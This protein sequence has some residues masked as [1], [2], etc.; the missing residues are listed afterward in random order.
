[1][2]KV[3]AVTGLNAGENPQPGAGVIRSLRRAF[4]EL[5]IV[6]LVYGALESAIYAED[7]PDAVYQIPYPSAGIDPLLERLD[8]LMAHEPIDLFIPTLDAEILPLI[9][10]QQA[11]ADR[12]IVTS[13]PSP[14]SFEARNKS[15][16]DSLVKKCGAQVPPGKAIHSLAELDKV[17][18]VL[19]F[20]L[21][22]K[23]PYYDAH[24]AHTHAELVGHFH[25]IMLEW[26]GPV[27][28]QS[29]I[30]GEE[31]NIT[32]LG[33][34]LGGLSAC[35]MIRKSIRSA[36]GKGFGGVVVDDPQL[37][38]TCKRIIAELKWNGPMELEFIQ[39]ETSGEFYLLEMNP[40]FPAWIDFPARI[41]CNMPVMLLEQM[42]GKP[43][44][45]VPVQCPVGHFFLRHSVDLSGRIE[46]LGRL[47]TQGELIW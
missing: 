4:N 25:S 30:R 18:E 24:L 10:A 42:T 36:K 44:P 33:D 29:F 2:K 34:G 15:R 28:V 19:A 23:G 14:E 11:L 32:G 17:L 21:M 6:G 26:G 22:V 37:L 20:P 35:C 31:F 41:G 5:R 43:L 13:L 47:T 7:G 12:G 16:L 3:V 27:I 46:D 9:H 40:R 45:S 39:D 38:E 1:M 8:E